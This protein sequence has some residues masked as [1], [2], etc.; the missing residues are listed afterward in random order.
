MTSEKKE[1]EEGR[2]FR[3]MRGGRSFVTWNQKKKKGGRFIAV[4]D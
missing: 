3:V 4:T 2:A 1:G